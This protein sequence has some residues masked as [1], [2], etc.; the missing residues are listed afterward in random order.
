MLTLLDSAISVFQS[1]LLLVPFSNDCHDIM[2]Q[3][4]RLEMEC[5][6]FSLHLVTLILVV[7]ILTRL[8]SF[9]FARYNTED[10]VAVIR[11]L[12]LFMTICCIF[13]SFELCRWCLVWNYYHIFLCLNK[14]TFNM[15]HNT[16]N[17]LISY[18]S[19]S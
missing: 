19:S 14:S 6:R 2:M 3:F 11:H 17:L 4:L 8:V 13:A 18:H 1:L 9:L 10:L 15:P 5:L 16:I 7:M 12:C